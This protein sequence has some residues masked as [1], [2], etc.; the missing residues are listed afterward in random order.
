MLGAGATAKLAAEHL[1][2]LGLEEIYIC[3]RN[4]E[5]GQALAQAVRG[6]FVPLKELAGV[7]EQ[8]DILATAVSTDRPL[9][10]R[11]MV[12][13]ALRKARPQS[14]VVLDMGLPPKCGK[15]GQRATKRISVRCRRSQPSRG[16]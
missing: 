12:E 11:S 8:V 1:A 16:Y 6:Q 7:L 2:K 9:V 10:S 13:E 5:R 3:N 14:F 4:E 15:H